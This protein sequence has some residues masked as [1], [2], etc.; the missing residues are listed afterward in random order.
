[1]QNKHEAHRSDTY[2][3]PQD[4]HSHKNMGT[5]TDTSYLYKEQRTTSTHVGCSKC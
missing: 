5:R 2:I 1:M 4:F 3:V